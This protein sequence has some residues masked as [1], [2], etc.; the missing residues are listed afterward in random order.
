MAGARV[1]RLL[2]EGPVLADGDGLA[3]PAGP[4]DVRAVAILDVVAQLGVDPDYDPVAHL[5]AAVGQADIR[6]R[7]LTEQLYAVAPALAV[8]VV[9]P[10]LPLLLELLAD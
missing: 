5:I 8:E 3:E 4:L 10:P 1:I 2:S 7:R 9:E 6:H